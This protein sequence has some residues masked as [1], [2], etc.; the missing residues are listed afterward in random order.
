MVVLPASALKKIII[1][2]S[3][4]PD[5]LLNEN[6]MSV[7]S[8]S[9]LAITILVAFYFKIKR[10]EIIVFS[11]LIASLLLF[12]SSDYIVQITGIVS[13]FR[14]STFPFIFAI[15]GYIMYLAWKVNFQ[16][17]KSKRLHIVLMHIKHNKF[18]VL[19]KTG[20]G[21]AE[22]YCVKKDYLL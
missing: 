22:I 5:E 4:F 12:Y 13:R 17:F 14:L 21:H 10:I 9:I 11:S 20:I 8:L 6:L 16:K 15:F 2:L 1:N 18:E 19:A 3:F 7:L